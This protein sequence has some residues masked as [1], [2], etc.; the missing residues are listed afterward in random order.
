MPNY[1]DN[2]LVLVCPT[3][4]ADALAAALEGP[5]DWP[6]PL[7]ILHPLE[8]PKI[9]QSAH[10]K[11]T[12]A[13][14][15]A[16]LIPRFHALAA[17]WGWPA[18]MKPSELDLAFFLHA[19][20]K[21]RPDTVPFSIP[22]LAPFISKDETDRVYP[23]ATPDSPLWTPT[24]KTDGLRTVR[25]ERVGT[26]WPP[27]DHRRETTPLTNGQTRILLRHTTPWSP[28]ANLPG[29]LHDLL[30]A[31]DA[32]AAAWWVEED[33]YSG[34]THIDPARDILVETEFDR[35][36]FM[37]EEKDA[38]LEEIFVVFDHD[39]LDAHLRALIDDPDFFEA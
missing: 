27:S 31:H 2:T 11:L 15:A 18:W 20:E 17:E 26:K 35:K 13:A 1:V 7:E 30:R 36:N 9:D 4:Q 21:L 14:D 22:K 23:D 33:G 37:I 16:D 19:P 8:R 10:E 6:Y 24:E 29:L 32:K 12:L 34:A 38:D 28:V 5:A 3:A 39:A 25:M